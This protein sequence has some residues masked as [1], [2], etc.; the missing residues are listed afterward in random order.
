MWILN[1][2]LESMKDKLGNFTFI[3]K[4][5]WKK[6]NI[7]MYTNFVYKSEIAEAALPAQGSECTEIQ[8]HTFYRILTFGLF[9]MQNNGVTLFFQAQKLWSHFKRKTSHM[10]SNWLFPLE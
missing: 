4:I 1:S 3:K 10:F 8:S 7:L 6:K 2:S 5:E 9:C